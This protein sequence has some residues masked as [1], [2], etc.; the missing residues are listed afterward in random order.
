MV[1]WFVVAAENGA[2]GLGNNDWTAGERA[3]E[4]ARTRTSAAAV[5]ELILILELERCTRERE[6][7]II[8]A[9]R[10]KQG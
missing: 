7:T 5:M 4:R 9:D 6:D 3:G 1:A 10:A 2:V 8:F